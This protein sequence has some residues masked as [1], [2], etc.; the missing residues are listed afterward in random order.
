M[1]S[2]NLKQTIREYENYIQKNGLDEAVIEAYAEACSVAITNERDVKYGLS[3]TSRAKEITESYCMQNHMG[4]GK[5]RIQK[6][7][8]F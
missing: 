4:L 3:L 8:E 7:A 1:V 6:Q 5:I 2:E